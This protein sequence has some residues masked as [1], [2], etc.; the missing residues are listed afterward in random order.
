MSKIEQHE[1]TVNHGIA[2]G[3]EGIKTPPLQGINEVLHEKIKGHAVLSQ[4][5]F[6]T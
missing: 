1:N 5:D 3:D 6:C 2:Q 4:I